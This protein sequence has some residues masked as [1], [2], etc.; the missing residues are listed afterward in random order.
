VVGNRSSGC[1]DGENRIF[2]VIPAQGRDD[3]ESDEFR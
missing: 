1:E 2:F 3:G